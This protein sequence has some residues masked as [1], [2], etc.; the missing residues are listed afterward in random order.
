[1]GKSQ[2]SF[3]KKEREKKRQKKRENKL[4]R[5]EERKE[6]RG[7]GELD[8][9]MAYVDEYGNL[10]D[11]PPDP[12]QKKK[13][14]VKDIEIGT[15]KLEKSIK[16][17][18]YEGTVSFFDESKGY[19]FI[20]DANSSNQYFVHKTGLIDIIEDNDKVSFELEKGLKGMNAIN[21]KKVN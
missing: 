21:V 5:K 9:M 20:N 3:N 7:S 17:T 19:G 11:I 8:D 16:E 4:K 18:N 1:M 14:N 12:S 15:P 10:T 13:I 6:N 2:Q